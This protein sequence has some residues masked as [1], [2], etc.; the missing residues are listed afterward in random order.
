[1][2]DAVGD[3]ERSAGLDRSYLPWGLVSL[4]LAVAVVSWAN[5]SVPEGENGGP[6]S[7][8]PVSLFCAVVAAGLFLW[9][10]PRSRNLLRTGLVLGALAVVTVP[11]FWSGLPLVLGGAAFA[12]GT[13]VPEG[14][15]AAVQALGA[16]AVIGAVAAVAADKLG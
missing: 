3:N 12:A 11:V 1:M 8:L 13:K 2:S 4:A 9:L 7:I 6:E 5:T 15:G 10:L 16:V 14:K